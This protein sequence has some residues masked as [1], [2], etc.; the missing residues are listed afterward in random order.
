MNQEHKNQADGGNANPSRKCMVVADY[1]AQFPDPIS[2]NAGETFSVSDKVE[3]WN[4]N[5]DWL[6]VWCIDQRGKSGWV[7]LDNIKFA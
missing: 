5:P 7:P 4:D 6:W 1:S 2:V 3:P